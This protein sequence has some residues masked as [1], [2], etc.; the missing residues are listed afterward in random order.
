[1]LRQTV[2]AALVAL[3]ACKG[4]AEMS[5]ANLMKCGGAPLKDTVFNKIKA[6]YSTDVTVMGTTLSC[7]VDYEPGSVDKLFNKGAVKE[8]SVAGKAKGGGLG[9]AYVL[10]HSFGKKVQTLKTALSLDVLG[11]R[12]GA[13]A[14]FDSKGK[15]E[16]TEASLAIIEPYELAEFS[17]KPLLVDTGVTYVGKSSE[18]PIPLVATFTAKWGALVSSVEQP[19]AEA[20]PDV[21]LT[22]SQVL[23][24]G[25]AIGASLALGPEEHAG[26]AHIYANAKLVYS[27]SA[28]EK[29]A[30][31]VAVAEQPLTHLKGS[32]VS[33]SRAFAF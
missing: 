22:A 21:K 29:G 27:D 9:L 5:T 32:K 20:L 2:F 1:M 30:T 7:A 16:V 33:L 10:S 3:A 28:V 26:A 15:S 11:E 31:W 23:G 24:K 18:Y 6:K 19:I 17:G 14:V 4:K 13:K 8:V 25:R 12:F